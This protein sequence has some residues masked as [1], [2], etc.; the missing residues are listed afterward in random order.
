MAQPRKICQTLWAKLVVKLAHPELPAAYAESQ[1][2]RCERHDSIGEL[3]VA[4][5]NFAVERDIM[6]QP[7]LQDDFATK[8]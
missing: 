3:T 6:D 4:E 1:D 5:K 8:S 7:Y 2:V